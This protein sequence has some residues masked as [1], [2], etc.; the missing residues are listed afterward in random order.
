MSKHFTFKYLFKFFLLIWSFIGSHQSMAQTTYGNEWI[1]YSQKYYKIQV[2]KNGI[3]RL[4]YNY[5]SQAGLANVDPRNFQI[6]RRGKEQAIFVSG[7]EDGKLD[8]ADYI[9]FYGERNDGKTDVELY[10]DPSKKLHSYY[11]LYT[12]TAAYFLTV[13]NT[14]GRRMVNQNLSNAGLSQDPFHIQSRLV[15]FTSN[16]NLGFYNGISYLPWVSQGEGFFGPGFGA[17][18]NN[19]AFNANPATFRVDSLLHVEP[20]APDPKIE[21]GF[22]GAYLRDHNITISVVTPSGAERPIAENIIFGAW[23]FAKVKANLRPSDINSD[24][25]LTVR[26]KVNTI[27]AQGE[28]ADLIMPAYIKVT[29]GRKNVITGKQAIISLA[30]STK[31]TDSFL[32]FDSSLGNLVAYDITDETSIIRTIGKTEGGKSSFVFGGGAG[33]QRKI[34]LNP[35]TRFFVPIAPKPINFKIFDPT[36]PNF[37]IVSHKALTKSFSDYSNPVRAYADYRASTAGGKYDTL[38]FY[39]DQV[40]DQFHYGDHSAVAIRRLMNFLIDKGQPK[41][42]FL[43]GKGIDL[44][45]NVGGVNYRH[46]PNRFSV[47]DLV[48]V[49]GSP[50]SDVI[51]TADFQRDS[52]FPRVPTGRLVANKSE[53]IINYLEKVKQHET[54]PENAEWRK[55][56]MHLSGGAGFSQQQ[57]FLNYIRTYQSIAEGPLLGANVQTISKLGSTETSTFINLSKQVNAGL[58]LITFFG[59][60]ST[61][62]ADIDIGYVSNPVNGYNNFGKYPMILLNGCQSGN[63]SLGTNSRTFGEDWIITPKKGAINFLA[64]SSTGADL[65]LHVYSSNFYNLAFTNPNFYGKSIGQIVQETARR[66]AS[67]NDIEYIVSAMYMLLQGDPAIAVVGPSKPDYAVEADKVFLRSFTKGEPITATSDRFQVVIPVRNFGKAVNEPLSVSIT[68]NNEMVIDSVFSTPVYNQDTLFVNVNR[69]VNRAGLSQFEVF[70][71]HT[72]KVDELDEVNNKGV[73]QYNFPASSV[74]PLWPHEFALVN[75]QKVKLM[76]QATDL[77]QQNR[78]YYFE[79]DT[80]PTFKST[81]KQTRIVNAGIY[82]SVQVDLKPNVAPNDSLVYYWRFRFKEI[83]AGTDTIWGTSSFR[84]IPTSPEGWSQS[85]YGQLVKN[86]G[87]SISLNEQNKTWEFSSVKKTISIRTGGGQVS[88]AFPPFG[89]FVNGVRDFDNSCGFGNPNVLIK[90]FSNKTLE[91]F[92]MPAEFNGMLC[93]QTPRAFYQFSD[94]RSA[95][96]Q[97]NLRKFLEAVPAGYFVVLGSVNN[98]PFSGFSAPLKE[99]F[100]KIGSKLID[101]LATGSPFAIIGQQGAAIGSVQEVSATDQ[102]GVVA[103]MQTIEL[104]GDIAAP[105]ISG[106]ITST[107]IGPASDWQK[108]FHTVRNSGKG[109]DAYQLKVFGLNLEGRNEAVL[110]EKVTDRVLDISAIDAKQYPYLRLSLDVEDAEDRTPPQLREW[111]VHYTGVPE[112]IIRTDTIGVDKYTN[113]GAKAGQGKID[114]RFAFQNIS[115]YDFKDSLVARFTLIGQNGFTKDVKIKALNRRDMVTFPFA[116]ATNGL[117]G[118]YTLRLTVNP[119]T[120][121]PNLQPEQYYFNNTLELPFTIGPNL[122]PVLDVVFDGQ[123]IMNGDIVSPNPIISMSLKDEDRF[124]F[125]KDASQMEVFIKLPNATSYTPVNL[126]GSDI[127]VYPADEKNDFRLEYTPK[128]L[129]DGKYSLRV[130]GKDMANN[131]S[132]FDPYTI[133]FEVINELAVTHFYPYPNPFSSKTRFVFTLTGSTIPQNMKIQIMTITGKVIREIM[134]EELGPLKIGNNISEYAW[135][136]TDEYGDKLA[137]GVYL[138]RVVMDTGADEFKHRKTSTTADKSFK[139]DYGKIYIL[140]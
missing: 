48:P 73:F 15:L 12:D 113:L 137:N 32:S 124:T 2:A 25:I 9:E 10:K 94:L 55:N 27:V 46:D 29:Y 64:H 44:D 104:T 80:S 68:I 42:L 26:V 72:N 84:Y 7:E 20:N 122:A 8:N 85:E 52:F 74:R 60:S 6:F 114:L 22:S 31:S 57:Q 106:T 59:H 16:Y 14:G 101:D 131:A 5:L 134:K 117:A 23:E 139:K 65:P 93:G 41:H 135:D 128:N 118:R 129:P 21:L 33:H 140:R 35:V 119:L 109:N 82:P 54:I 4:D 125:I 63:V 136:G 103:G 111:M 110:F 120:N 45:Q 13:S 62:V 78:D 112:G 121:N 50:A 47:R 39:A 92:I 81:D 40:Y 123:H 69:P 17:L 127:K 49:G 98:V 70:V 19:R 89:I 56:L 88:P 95:Q 133:E 58:S 28:Y 126:S 105:G 1:N 38:V 76:G 24:G 108:L 90:V 116:L 75:K 86:T 97:E 99:A 37:I 83:A 11:S 91:A 115:E 107:L 79:V 138:Y 34:L 67:R 96:N 100:R 18:A 3:H 43:I 53:E 61:T 87:S 77:L 102:N 36:K 130:Q 66:T 132:G 30:D 51:F 71:D